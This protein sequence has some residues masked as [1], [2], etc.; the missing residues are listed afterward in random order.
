MTVASDLEIADLQASFT[1]AIASLS[2]DI[3][4]L[5]Q[6][7]SEHPRYNEKIDRVRLLLG[8]LETATA[9]ARSMVSGHIDASANLTKLV[10]YVLAITER[11]QDLAEE[12]SVHPASKIGKPL[13]HPAGIWDGV[14]SE[15]ASASA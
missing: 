8:N 15:T 10:E 12:N 13:G 5:V 14:G 4:R 11:A 3:E 9:C 6:H 7:I 1:T 2:K